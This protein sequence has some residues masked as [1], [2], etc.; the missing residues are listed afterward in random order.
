M[1]SVTYGTL[2]G[3]ASA[4]V[5]MTVVIFVAVPYIV[6]RVRQ[7]KG[8][9]VLCECLIQD[10]FNPKQNII[11]YQHSSMHLVDIYISERHNHNSNN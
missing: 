7:G 3:V 2:A 4:C 11:R 5:I 6:Q 10:R 9:H 1:N 8:M